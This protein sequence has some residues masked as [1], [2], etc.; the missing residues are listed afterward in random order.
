MICEVETRS[1]LYNT[2]SFNHKNLNK[3]AA[4]W[5]E[6]ARELHVSGRLIIYFP[7]PV[8]THVNITI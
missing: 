2:S 4:D 8:K 7:F 6:I 5:R 3:V 1:Y